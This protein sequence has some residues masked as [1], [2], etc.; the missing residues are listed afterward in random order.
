M[1]EARRPFYGRPLWWMGNAT[2]IAGMFLIVDFSGGDWTTSF[3]GLFLAY[4]SDETEGGR[5]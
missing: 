1:R 5:R 3:C 2:F 4:L